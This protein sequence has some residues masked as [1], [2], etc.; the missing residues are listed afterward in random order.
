MLADAGLVQVVEADRASAGPTWRELGPVAARELQQ[1]RV[2]SRPA[3]PAVASVTDLRIADGI[4][5]R[6]YRPAAGHAAALAVFLHGGMWTVG[7]LDSHDRPCRRMALAT[8]SAVLAIDYRRAPEYPA[9]A[10]VDDAV[11]AIL[12]ASAGR[13]ELAGD[14]NCPLLVVGDSSGGNL[15]TLAC[16]RIRDQKRALPAAQVLIYPNTD[17][18]LSLPTAREKASGWGITTDIIAWGAEFWVPDAARRADPAVS[19]LFEPD[20]G[21]LPPAAIVTA[22]HD[23]L[24]DEG[25]AYA[26]RLEAAGTPVFL[27]R[28]PAMIHGFL[29]LDIQSPAAAAAGERIFDDMTRLIKSQ[30]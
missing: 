12:W 14:G 9:P 16:L 23:P 24:R 15:A 17:L 7:S 22:E 10:A 8:E 27:R 11:A 26:A 25:E 5:A 3:G 2:A 13:A 18:T 19:P 6:L 1:A 30:R 28:E 4:D 29:N 20:L 21:G